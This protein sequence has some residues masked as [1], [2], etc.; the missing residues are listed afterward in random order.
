MDELANVEKGQCLAYFYCA[1][2][3]S[4]PG[5]ADPTHVFRSIMRQM[6]TPRSD[7][8]ELPPSVVAIYG[9]RDKKPAEESLQIAKTTEHII[10]LA[11]RFSATT[12]VIDALDECEASTR[13]K[14][15]S[16]LTEIIRRS[17]ALIKI[18]VSS[19]NDGEIMGHLQNL[20]HI[21]VDESRNGS[22]IHEYVHRKVEEAIALKTL[23]R[24]HPSGDFKEE[25][26]ETLI[27]GAQGM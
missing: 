5:R 23:L 3:P 18:L 22:D 10:N 11:S 2:N 13:Y 27:R 7:A 19:R 16:G 21:Y 26:I 12:I 4:E 20:P 6:S 8:A 15:L 1:R 24:G 14:V 25:L 17:S 9:E